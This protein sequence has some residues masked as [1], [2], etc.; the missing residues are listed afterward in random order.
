MP[1]PRPSRRSMLGAGALLAVAGAVS[2]CSDGQHTR[3]AGSPRRTD[4][5]APD[6]G[7]SP[8]ERLVSRARGEIQAAAALVA[9]T[10]SQRPR[11]GAGLTPWRTL[12]EQHLE[13]LSG[14]A[15]STRTPSPTVVVPPQPQAALRQVLEHERR[16]GDGLAALALQAQSGALA[17]ALAGMSAAIAQRLEVPGP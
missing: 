15:T 3:S 4:P 13:L 9:S 10:T 17:R 5:P 16:L 12:H 14:I 8:D 1:E 2:G 7:D 11:L 6:S